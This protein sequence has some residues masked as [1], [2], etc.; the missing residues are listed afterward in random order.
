MKFTLFYKI[1]NRKVKMSISRI[2]TQGLAIIIILIL[3]LTK[4]ALGKDQPKPLSY[5]H[6]QD[7]PQSN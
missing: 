5:Q 1:N 4:V 2:L 6:P 3:I 7:F